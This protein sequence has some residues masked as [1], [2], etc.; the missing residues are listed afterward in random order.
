MRR[1]AVQAGTSAVRVAG[2]DG[3]PGVLAEVAGPP[4]PERVGRV[5]AEVVGPGPGAG[6]V[7]V[8]RDGVLPGVRDG[9]G[10][11]VPGARGMDAGWA[12][13]WGPGGPGAGGAGGVGGPWLVVDAGH[14]GT[15]VTRV[16]P[17]GRCVARRCGIGGARLDDLVAGMLRAPGGP[18]VPVVVARQARES[19]SLLPVVTVRPPSGAELRLGSPAV[20]AVL[21]P[22]LAQVAEEVARLAGPGPVP[23]LLVGGL[24]R[25]PLLAELLDAAGVGPVTVAPRPDAAA[26]LGALRAPLPGEGPRRSGLGAAAVELPVEPLGGP[27]P[28]GARPAPSAGSGG[29]RL[30]PPPP[31]RRRGTSALLAA[32]AAVVVAAFALAPDPPPPVEP[33]AVA[34]YGYVLLLPD[35]WVHAGGLP[36]RRRV[37]LAPVAAPEGSDV[38]TVERTPLGYDATAEPGRAVADLRAAFDAAVAGGAPLAGFA[39][40][41][42]FAGRP[43]ATYREQ[44]GASGVDWYVLLDVADQ[45]SVGCRHTAAGAQAV[46][47]ACAEVV[48]SLALR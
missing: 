14:G 2:D 4:T 42:R 22:L 12:A 41:A 39:P 16:E 19:L 46:A 5:L 31:R 10:P 20:R 34:Q 28:P 24:A 33:G 47:R 35:G 7:V 45:V 29:A 6:E 36:E 43:V 30:P 17:D 37:L 40:A 44:D 32:V 26:V 18:E 21:R 15:T 1:L 23:V 38:V 25:T 11:L 9:P 27:A 3:A 8:L 13:L 48:G